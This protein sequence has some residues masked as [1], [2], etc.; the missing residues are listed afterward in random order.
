MR[1]CNLDNDPH[2]VNLHS[3]ISKLVQRAV[4]QKLQADNELKVQQ[5]A[6]K[7]QALPKIL[8]RNT[9]SSMSLNGDGSPQSISSSSIDEIQVPKVP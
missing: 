6:Y 7:A 5:V 3:V 1:E 4:L 8:E 9:N 2:P